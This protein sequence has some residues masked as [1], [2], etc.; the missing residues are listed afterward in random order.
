MYGWA[1][2]RLPQPSSLRRFL[3][4]PAIL[5]LRASLKK[6]STPSEKLI[7][8]LANVAWN[9]QKATVRSE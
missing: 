8:E 4:F 3:E 7:L 1:T 6:Y 9:A 2:A 5:Q